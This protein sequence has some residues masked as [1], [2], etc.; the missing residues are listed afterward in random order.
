MNKEL[1][2]LYVEDDQK[3]REDLVNVLQDDEIGGFVINI[4]GIDSFEEAYR[5]IQENNYHLVI[6]D[7]FDGKPEDKGEQLGLNILEEIQENCFIPIIF[8]SGNTKDVLSLKSQIVGI[9]TKGDG[10]VEELKNEIARLVKFN[11][12]FI[13]ENIHNHIEQELKRYFWDIIHKQRAKFT[14]ENNDFSLG[15]LMLRQFGNSLS[16]EK[17]SDILENKELQQDKVH[18]MEFYLYPTDIEREL[19]CGEILQKDNDIFVVLTPSCD[20]IERFDKKGESLGRKVGKILLTRANLLTDSDEYI[21]FNTNK[22][23]DNITKLS[24]VISSGK[25]DRYFFLPGTPFIENRVIDF[26]NK[27]MI[28]YEELRNFIRLAK[29][30]NP[31]AEAVVASFI[32]YYNRIGYPDIDSN[33]IIDNL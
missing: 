17:I 29:L 30:D 2:I 33:F 8:F 4:E 11:L 10:G 19:E 31:F 22:N 32:R 16:K 3:N 18:P 25:S 1:R 21:A 14:A 23:N 28:E 15:Y 12:P 7:I 27:L 13:K 6:L 5:K 26:Q 9:A 20:F 24:K